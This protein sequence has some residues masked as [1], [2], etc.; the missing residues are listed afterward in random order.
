MGELWRFLLR[1]NG[2][3]VAS[4]DAPTRAAATAEGMHYASMYAQDDPVR[5]TVRRVR[6][7]KP[8]QG[9]VGESKP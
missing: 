3:V 6:P 9:D 4:G 2:M 7:R 8:A 5:L 1:Q